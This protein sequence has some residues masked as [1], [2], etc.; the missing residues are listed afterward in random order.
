MSKYK[1]PTWFFLITFIFSWLSW[2]PIISFDL[3]TVESPIGA[4]LFMLGGFG[5]SIVGS[6]FILRSE[7]EEER[8]NL[9]NRIFDPR[10]IGWPWL[11]GALLIYPI[12]FLISVLMILPFGGT[13]PEAEPLMTMLMGVGPF[14]LNTIIILLLGPVSEEVGWRGYALEKM[15]QFESPMRATLIIGVIWWAW[16]LPLFFMPSTLHGSQGL[17]SFFTV[18]YFFTVLSYSIL[19]TWLY[20]NTRQSILIT[21]LAHFSI[22]FTIGTLSPFD[23]SLFAI[24][25]VLILI[26]GIG[27]WLRDRQLGFS[28]N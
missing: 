9:W 8:K 6:I 3:S 10:R 1:S 23:G 21:I 13:W 20:N 12:I 27:L 16:H 15:Q 2:V 18:G 22:N 7:K 26:L 19:F 4:S 5:P 28:K 11:L 24:T 17:L 25:T 14:V